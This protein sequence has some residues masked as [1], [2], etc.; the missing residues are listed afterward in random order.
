MILQTHDMNE[1]NGESIDLKIYKA[2]SVNQKYMTELV[3]NQK[4]TKNYQEDE[5]TNSRRMLSDMGTIP[6]ND[7][8]KQ[9]RHGS[10]SEY[11]H[12]DDEQLQMEN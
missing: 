3:S 7:A 11:V 10:S 4:I 6:L 12:T 2:N 9:N 8:I 5:G 1:H